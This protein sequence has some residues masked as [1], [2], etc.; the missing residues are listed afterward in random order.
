M[1]ATMAPP[2]PAADHLARIDFDLTG[3]RQKLAAPEEGEGWDE[4]KL[5][6]AEQEYRRFMA[7]C[8]AY[9]E[10]SIVP[11][12]LVDQFWHQHI[13]DTA[14]YREDCDRVF[15]HFYDHYPYFGLNGPED[16]AN[17]EHAYEITLDL[18]ELNFGAT[19]DG[20]WQG[21]AA[22]KCRSRCRTGCKPMKCK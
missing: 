20:A 16:A 5:H 6:L 21:S 12:R 11:C 15:G 3:V 13:L 1:T 9:P 2:R 22:G 10:E 19:P 7:L 18:Y 8:I 17:L 4:H 14:A